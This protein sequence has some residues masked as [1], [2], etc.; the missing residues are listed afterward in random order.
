M[1]DDRALL[2]ENLVPTLLTVDENLN[3]I[4]RAV[5][6]DRK[7]KVLQ[8][9]WDPS[10]GEW[11]RMQQPYLETHGN[12]Y[13]EV[14]EVEELL[15]QIRNRLPLGA[16]CT[17]DIDDYSTAY[18]TY[19]GKETKDGEW[20]IMKLDTS[21]GTVIRY[22]TVTNNPSYTTYSSAWAARASLNYDPY[23]DVF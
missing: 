3:E 20:L 16:Y 22:A 18:V 9:V 11:V 7:I 17:N 6:E 2:D 4:R 5:S 14:D 23:A 13:L 10:T 19:I 1:A 12:I 21:S 15:E 8:Y